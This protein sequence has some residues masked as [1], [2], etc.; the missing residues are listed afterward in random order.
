MSVSFLAI[1]Y[2]KFISRRLFLIFVIRDNARAFSR[3]GPI[4][5]LTMSGEALPHS[6]RWSQRTLARSGGGKRAIFKEDIQ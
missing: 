5:G 3:S 4:G 1:N 2:L 6:L